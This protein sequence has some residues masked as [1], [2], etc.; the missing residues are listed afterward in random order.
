MLYHHS[1][2]ADKKPDATAYIMA[3]SNEVVTWKEFDRGI[4]R[5][6]RYFKDIGLKPKDH[7]ALCM[8]NNSRY[9][10]ITSA[11]ADAGL[12]FTCISTH[13]KLSETQYIINNCEAKV[14]ITSIYKKDL[15]TELIPLM[16][17]VAH[18]LMIGGTVEGYDAYEEA[19]ARYPSDPVPLGMGGRAML[20]SSGTTGL[21]KGVL[22][23]VEDRP[24]GELG[25]S[26]D[27]MIALYQMNED[28]VYLSPAPLYHS[29]PLT[30]CGMTLAVGGTVIVMEKFDAEESLALIEKY[31]A[32]H[33]QWVP[34]MF[35]RMLKLPAEIREKY[36]ISSMKLAIHAAA[37]TPIEVKEQMIKWWGPVFL[38]YYGGTEGSTM[39][40]ISSQE[41]LSHK[42]SVG[43]CYIG[44]IHILA[45]DE[46]D[47]PAGESGLIFIEDGNPFEYH[48]EP[49]KTAGSRTSKGWSTMGDIGYLDEEGYLYLTDRKSN[50]II[51]GG[52]NIYPQET[53]NL[54][55]M[56][57]K[58]MDAAVFGIP[59]EE[60][61]EEVKAIV[62]PIHMAEAGPDLE[63]ELIEYC[64]KHLSHV[65]CPKSIDFR[66]DLPRTPTGK[67]VKRLL[68]D[69]YWKGEKRI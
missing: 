48:K 25:P 5:L 68:K 63:K 29:A 21:P 35:I 16:P 60:F 55:T 12:V 36:D 10:E 11:A 2:Y 49:E 46:N 26:G 30:F 54:L 69:E 66:E 39:I 7:I 59:H 56:H 28:A 33:S 45:E 61:G 58:V 27:V 4:N 8:E 6:V 14:F 3:K 18:R 41:W 1:T 62:Q 51:S 52:V 64:R 38:E 19:T 17:D 67:L 15:A 47:M 20:Y 42:G 65:K 9:F 57:P 32:T 22:S 53:E 43:K 24:V 44:K 31:K 37:P 50:M 40:M 34:T 13:L 23:T